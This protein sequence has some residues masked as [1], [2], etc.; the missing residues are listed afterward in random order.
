V[1]QNPC[2]HTPIQPRPL[3][4]FDRAQVKD[5]L[6]IIANYNQEREI[7]D[8]LTRAAKYFPREQ[9]VVIDDGS[10]DTS[11]SLARQAGYQVICHPLNM[12][13]GAAIRTGIEEAIR[14]G[15]KWVMI[16]SSNGKIRPE[17]FEA[18]YLP[19]SLGQADYTTGSRFAKGSRHPGLPL[20]RRIAI[21]VFSF[22]SSLLLGRYYSDITCGFRAYTIDI[23]RRSGANI[24]QEWL[25]RYDLEY[26]LHYYVTKT[27][28]ARIVE[29]PVTIA[30]AHLEKGRTSKIKPFVGWWS[31]IR[32]LL[33]LRMGI[34]K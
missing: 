16:S 26:Y 14:R 27:K 3:E 21:P 1:K 11:A 28:D 29:I 13:I 31:M 20:F 5:G 32:P 33:F 30:Y 6:L 10:T 22:F 15:M 34:R 19:V 12:G 25:N 4:C 8:Y 2:D 23:L 9:S 7:K 18:V 17:D 24:G